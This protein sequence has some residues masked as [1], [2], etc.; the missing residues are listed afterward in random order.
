MKISQTSND[1]I[2]YKVG[3]CGKKVK[4]EPSWKVLDVGSGHN[5]F[6]RANVLLDKEFGESIHRSGKKAKKYEHQLL[7]LGDATQMPFQNEEFDY[8]IASHIAEHIEDIDK[9][10]EELQRVSKRGY[11][12]TPGPISEIMLN[13]PYH[14]WIVYKK[15]NTL[16]FKKKR[17]FRPL[18][19]FFMHCFT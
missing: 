4:I 2:W 17:K 1:I 19:K 15:G 11:I 18:S 13:E 7:V 6:K 12:E 5:P 3:L 16:I 8:S 10:I 9:F 14:L